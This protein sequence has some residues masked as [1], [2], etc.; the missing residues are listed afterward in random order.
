[1]LFM[2]IGIIDADNK[3]YFPSLK[4]RLKISHCILRGKNRFSIIDAPVS[5]DHEVNHFLNKKAFENPLKIH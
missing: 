4:T 5:P 2:E 1:M 3:N